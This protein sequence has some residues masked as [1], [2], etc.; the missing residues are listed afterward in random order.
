MNVSLRPELQTYVDQLV[1]SGKFPDAASVF[2]SALCQMKD[3]DDW[4]VRNQGALRRELR[5]AR[6]ALDRGEGEPLDIDAIKAN[7]RRE[8]ERRGT[9]RRG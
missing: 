1:A 6:A 9:E 7:A 8:F 2:E 3:H 4:I 5:D